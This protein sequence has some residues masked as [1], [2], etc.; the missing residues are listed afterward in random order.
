MVSCGM[1]WSGKFSHSNDAIGI[2]S[3]DLHV[4]VYGSDHC[5]YVVNGSAARAMAAFC[6]V[7]FFA[8]A[9]G[10]KSIVVC[11]QSFSR[12]RTDTKSK[13]LYR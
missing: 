1:E 7:L 5:G 11:S 9:F 8:I 6:V 12:P 3:D 13:R 2:C 10:V 4:N